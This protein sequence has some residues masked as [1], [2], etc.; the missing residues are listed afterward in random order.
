MPGTAN[1]FLCSPWPAYDISAGPSQSNPSN[2]VNRTIGASQGVVLRVPVNNT[3]LP[4]TVTVS[5]ASVDTVSGSL[6]L[7]S[8]PHPSGEVHPSSGD[9][10]GFSSSGVAH[11]TPFGFDT[12]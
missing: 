5:A 10:H 12:S 7:Y 11:P 3:W 4:A 6:D 1:D 9:K 2:A 8:G